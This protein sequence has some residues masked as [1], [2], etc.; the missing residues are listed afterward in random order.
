VGEAASA[1]EVN[2]GFLLRH[3]LRLL[4]AMAGVAG[5]APRLLADLCR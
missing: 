5:E 1:T 2:T 4:L 3:E